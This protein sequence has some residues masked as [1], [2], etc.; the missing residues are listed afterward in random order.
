MSG[1]RERG[2]RLL[3]GRR[4]LSMTKTMDP[5]GQGQGQRPLVSRLQLQ[6]DLALLPEAPLRIQLPHRLQHEQV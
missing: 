1:W 4:H 3:A 2:S 5:D 6:V